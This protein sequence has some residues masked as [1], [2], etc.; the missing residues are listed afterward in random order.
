MQ[1]AV[2]R[3][4]EH[5]AVAQTRAVDDGGGLRVQRVAHLARAL[6]VSPSPV[7][8]AISR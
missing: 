4:E 7:E 1:E 5:E 3:G 6:V 8:V 2:V